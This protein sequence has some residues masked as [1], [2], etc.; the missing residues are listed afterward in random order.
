MRPLFPSFS[1]PPS[2]RNRSRNILSGAHRGISGAHRGIS[3]G[4]D[5]M[6]NW[7]R[8]AR[9]PSRLTLGVAAGTVATA[10]TALTVAGV[11]GGPS[12][13]AG[14]AGSLDAVGHST[15]A[16][17]AGQATLGQAAGQHSSVHSIQHPASS[18]PHAPAATPAASRAAAT[19]PAAPPAQPYNFYD[20]VSPSALPA[21]NEMA[22]V[23][24]TGNYAASPAQVAGRPVLW[25]D[26]TGTDYAAGAL[27]VEPGNVTPSQAGAWAY[28]RLQRNPNATAILYTFQNEWPAVQA[29]VAG[30]PSWMQSHIRWWIADPTGVPHIV[31]GSQATQWYWGPNYDESTALPGF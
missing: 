1:L 27:D 5:R 16:S 12:S 29:A 2:V 24:A 17:A 15:I 26:T 9:R 7:A 3:R 4:I 25:I 22:A 31:P 20:T 19:A 8:P 6:P 11:S 23:Y 13:P 21:G 14:Q 28:N 30:L 18:Q 10:V